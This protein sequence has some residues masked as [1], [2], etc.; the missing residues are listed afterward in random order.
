MSLSFFVELATIYP[1]PVDYEDY[2]KTQLY[3]TNYVSSIPRLYP[4][5]Q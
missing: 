1:E 2:I 3:D 4:W 5:P